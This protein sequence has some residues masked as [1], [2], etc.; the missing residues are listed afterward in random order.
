MH[1]KAFT[2]VALVL[3]LAGAAGAATGPTTNLDT[4]LITTDPVPVQAGEDADISFKVRNTGNAIADNV[5][6]TIVDSFPFTL[7]PDRQRTYHLGQV[8]PGQPYYISTEVLVADNAPDGSN[9]FVVKVSQGDVTFRQTIPVEVQS[10]DV[11]LN[12]A[13]LSTAPSTLTADMEDATITV[14]AVNNG[15][16]AADN[17]VLQLELP[18]SFRATSS[19][20][21]REALGTIQPGEVKRA[22]FTVDILPNAT[23]GMATVDAS[24]YWSDDTQHRE[25][26]SF[27]TYIAGRPQFRVVDVSSNLTAGQTGPLRVTVKNVGNEQA[28]ATRV[29]V[30]DSSDMPFSYASASQYVGTLEPGMTGT[31]VFEVTAEQGAAIKDY[32]L[33]VEIRGVQDTTTYTETATVEVPLQPGTGGGLPVPLLAGAVL[34]VAVGGYLG[35]DRI[36]DLAGGV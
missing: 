33:D 26:T 7:K 32:L 6:V 29:R 17:V 11:E 16:E 35:R 24:L 8:A 1:M 3:L 13:G 9:D 20:T 30:L 12:L 28:T 10:Q 27:Q 31:A 18:S 14:E 2:T 25:A 21:T 23:K 4:T 5:T 15:E 36:R 19:F 34:V 22:S